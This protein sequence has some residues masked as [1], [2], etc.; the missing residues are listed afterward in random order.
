MKMEEKMANDDQEKKI[1]VWQRFEN[2]IYGSE[3]Y[4]IFIV[5]ALKNQWSKITYAFFVISLCGVLSG[6]SGLNHVYKLEDMNVLEGTFLKWTRPRH[7]SRVFIKLEDNRIVKF[8]TVSL[9]LSEEKRLNMLVGE[10]VKCFF[11]NEYMFRIPCVRDHLWEI[12]YKGEKIL[13]YNYEFI[14]PRVIKDR[15]ATVIMFFISLF[16]LIVVYCQ[17]KK[18]A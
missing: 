10:K 15:R 6:D 18:Q 12:D 7:G 11:S 9:S 1:G 14:Y 8:Y 4:Q 2:R 5:R 13:N 17:N 3:L 16:L